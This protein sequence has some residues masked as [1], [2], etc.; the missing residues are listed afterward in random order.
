MSLDVPGEKRPLSRQL[1]FP[2]IRRW[3]VSRGDEMEP[4]STAQPSGLEG[5]FANTNIIV[6]AL[7]SFFCNCCWIFTIL[8]II[9]LVTFKHPQA[10]QNAMIVT[11]VSVISFVI[12]V[13][14]G[15]IY[16]ATHH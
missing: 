6:L 2:S 9:G 13:V 12:Q 7:L 4:A 3:F 14:G 10:K 15:G 5:F 1:L 8:G 11:I 16:Q